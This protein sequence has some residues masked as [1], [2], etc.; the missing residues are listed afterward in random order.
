MVD[1]LPEPELNDLEQRC[2]TA[3]QDIAAALHAYEQAH[4]WCARTARRFT[5]R[6]AGRLG[7]PQR[8]LRQPVERRPGYDQ[9]LL[10][11]PDPVDI[12]W[13]PDLWG[14]IRRQIESSTAN[15]QASAAQLANIRLSLQGTLAVTYFQLRVSI[16]RRSCLRDTIDAYT[17][18]LQ[19]TQTLLK[20][21]LSTQSDVARRGRSL[22]QP[23]PSSSTSGCSARNTSM[24][25]PC[26]WASPRPA[27]I[28][29]SSRSPATRPMRPP[30][31]PRSCLNAGRYRRR[32]AAGL[33]LRT[34]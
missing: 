28:F 33:R 22:K 34:R 19:L 11:L 18:T 32:G 7:H 26:W 24:R 2:A 29:P 10:G 13:E 30:A 21:G 25:L 16:C 4:D 12:S 1:D 9:E 20:G 3:N 6:R 23:G 8:S 5:D 31:C 14:G 27:S 15:A 17:Q